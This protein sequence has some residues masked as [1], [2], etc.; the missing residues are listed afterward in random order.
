MAAEINVED[1]L[2]ETAS[3]PVTRSDISQAVRIIL[4]SIDEARM[5]IEQWS[6]YF[7]NKGPKPRD[8]QGG[9]EGLFGTTHKE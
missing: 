3:E 9:G 7:G 5:C 8:V 6:S 2:G 4:D 1:Q